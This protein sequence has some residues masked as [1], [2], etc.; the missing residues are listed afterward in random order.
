MVSPNAPSAGTRTWLAFKKQGS[1]FIDKNTVT[2]LPLTAATE[3]N[4]AAICNRSCEP[5]T[6]TMLTLVE[7]MLEVLLDEPSQ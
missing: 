7:L 3:A 4:M 2:S 5:E 1:A 6:T